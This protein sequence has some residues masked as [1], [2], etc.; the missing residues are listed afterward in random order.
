MESPIVLRKSLRCGQAFGGE[1]GTEAAKALYLRAILSMRRLNTARSESIKCKR[2]Q[3][4]GR[5]GRSV[6]L[7]K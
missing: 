4:S 6:L 5:A 3:R 1:V 7:D 2:Y